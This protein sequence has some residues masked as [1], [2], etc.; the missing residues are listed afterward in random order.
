MRSIIVVGKLAVGLFQRL[1]TA[2]VEPSI[3]DM[4]G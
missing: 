3:D 4:E 2:A 1:E